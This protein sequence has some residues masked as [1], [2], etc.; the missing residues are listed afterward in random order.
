MQKPNGHTGVRDR[1]D[2]AARGP[3]SIAR[4]GLQ[5]AR[6]ASPHVVRCALLCEFNQGEVWFFRAAIH[7]PVGFTC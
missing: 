4:H 1:T 2:I 7:H 5:F 3:G 6:T